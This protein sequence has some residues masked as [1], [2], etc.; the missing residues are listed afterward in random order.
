MFVEL[1]PEDYQPGDEHRC[2]LL[3][4]ILYGTRD[5]AQNWEEEL[6]LTLS[7]LKIVE[8]KCVPVRVERLASK[9]RTLWQLCTETT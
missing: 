5:A 9:V 4:Y 7:D 3:Q 6:A 8:G 2:G 1:P